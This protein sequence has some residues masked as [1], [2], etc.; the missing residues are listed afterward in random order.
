MTKKKKKK[1]GYYE[2]SDFYALRYISTYNA[3]FS[4][5]VDRY[6]LLLLLLLKRSSLCIIQSRAIVSSLRD[7]VLGE[8]IFSSALL[9]KKCMHTRTS[10]AQRQSRLHMYAADKR[11]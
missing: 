7:F 6:I 10:I 4:L 9:I 11:E 1:R 5:N 3:L 2:L 8:I